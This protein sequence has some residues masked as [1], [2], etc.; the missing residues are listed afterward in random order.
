ME[1][2]SS[3]RQKEEECIPAASNSLKGG[4]GGEK[5]K[6]FVSAQTHTQRLHLPIFCC[7]SRSENREHYGRKCLY[8]LSGI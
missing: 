7:V 6:C 1:E 2:G 3:D 4:G 5:Q 8:C